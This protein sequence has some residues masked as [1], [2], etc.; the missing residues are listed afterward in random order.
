[1]LGATVGQLYSVHGRRDL[2][3]FFPVYVN[4]GSLF[5]SNALSAGINPNDTNYQFV[6]SQAD[7]VLR[8]VYTDLTPTNYMN[9]LLDTNESGKLANAVAMQITPSGIPLL[10]S[11]AAANYNFNFLN[12]I[13]T[14]NG[15]IILV[16]AATNT[17]QPLVLTIYHGANQI[18]QTSLYL[19]ISG[20]EQM[21]RNKTI[22]LNP[23]DGTVP[24]RLTDVS[25]PNEPDTI[26]KNFVFMHGYNVNP[27]EARGVAADM[28]KRMYWSGSHAKFWAVTWEGSDSKLGSVLTPNYHT[29]VVNAFNTAPLLANFIASLTNSGPVVAAAHSLGNMLTLSA[30]SDCHAPISQYFM[31]DA[32]VPIEAIDPAS[33]NVSFM[34]FSTWAGYSNRLFASYWYQLFP[35]N[36][37]RSTLFWNNRLGNLGSADVYNFYS[38]GEEV[39]RLTAGDPPLSTINLLV[40]QLINRFSLVNL[41]PDVPFGTYSWYWQEKGKGTCSGDGLIGSSHG[42]WK[43][44]TYWV[45]SHGNELS[46]AIMNN[47]TNTILQTQPMFDFNSTANNLLLNVDSELLAPASDVN[48]SAYA[49]TYRNRILADAIPAMSLVAG[50]NPVPKFNPTGHN[51]D[52]MTLKNSWPLG[53]TGGEAGMW[54]HSDFVQVAYTFTHQLFDTFVTT[55]NLK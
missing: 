25:V 44:S 24:D 37:A 47:T 29:N 36:D 16:E 42:G 21:F 5:Q 53:R 3:D 48:A 31:L 4:I 54:H 26:A 15:G 19:S 45:D 39:L 17:T 46:P 9:F 11:F 49:A 52:M 13:A 51:I 33:T 20:V 34:T 14:N 12:S 41:W 27:N 55:G 32:A 7:G 35:T 38:S 6:L 50:A 28:Y 18:A 2:V 40:T 43:F 22:M 10:N 23:A 30:I 8:F 1:M